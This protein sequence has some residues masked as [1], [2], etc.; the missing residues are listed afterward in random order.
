MPYAVDDSVFS[1]RRASFQPWAQGVILEKI[2]AIKT[3][4]NPRE[5]GGRYG[6]KWAYPIGK[7]HII[8]HIDDDNRVVKILSVVSIA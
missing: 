7:F 2:E 4:E 6:G 1:A 8:C 5:A 3:L